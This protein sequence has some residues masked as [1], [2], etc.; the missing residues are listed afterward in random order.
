MK[1]RDAP[2]QRKLMSVILLTCL[3]VLVLMVSAYIILEYY[4]FRKA[5]QNNVL[6]LGRVLASNSSAALAFDSPKDANEILNALKANPHIVEACLY[7]IDGEIFAKYP[8]NAPSGNFP[9]A[10]QFE[11]YRFDKGYISGF[12]AV[13]QEDKKLGTLYLKSDMEEMYAQLRHYGLIGLLLIAGS[14]ILAYML[15]KILQKSISEP[16]LALEQTARIISEQHDYSVRATAHGKD[17]VGA[18]TNAFNHMLT[19]IHDQNQEIISFNQNLELKVNERTQALQQQK[20]FVETI[21]NSSV[22]LVAVF[23]NDLNYIMLNKRADDYYEKKRENILGKNILEVFPEI[24]DSPMLRDLKKALNGEA[25]YDAKYKSPVLNR[26]FENYYIPLKDKDEKIY[27][28]LTL[29][30]DI[31]N[32]MEANEKLETVNTEL[33]KSNRDLEQFAYVASHDLQEPLRKIQTF[34]Q[35]MGDS[36]YDEEKQK[37]YHK[38]IAQAASRMQNLIQDVLNF[39]R[40]SKTEEAFVDIDLNKILE[41]L[42]NDFELIIREKEA[43]INHPVLPVIKGIPLQLSQLF[44]NI[45]SN[46]LKYNEK[47]PVI[48][49]SL[50]KLSAEEIKKNLKL[51]ENVSYIKIK[52]SD[53]GIGFEPQFSEQIFNIFQRLHGKQTYSGTGIGLAI[54]KK[55]VENHHGIIY[56]YSEPNIGATFTV[57]LPSQR[58]TTL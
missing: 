45:I 25:V 57:I 35:L 19:Q 8:V 36:F 18:L 15:S 44:S 43:V 34:T 42:K 5:A 13:M 39:S 53:N 28:V 31:T 10:I 33:L 37:N 7:D 11:G 21:I 22:D 9:S 4:S 41:N 12:N 14:L 54:C 32:I 49:I 17:E 26:S 29:G 1:L 52:F 16:I 51:S 56:A 6:T 58:N 46:A 48:N 40:I 20:D 38:K 24:K 47:K 30:H 2:I 23:D 50:E 27:G 55:I 3:T